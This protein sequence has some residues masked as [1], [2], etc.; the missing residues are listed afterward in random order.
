M[1]WF[2]VIGGKALEFCSGIR[3]LN[4]YAACL[5]QPSGLKIRS[6]EAGYFTNFSA[7]RRGRAT[8]S[9][10]QLGHRPSSTP[11]AH[12]RQNVHSN[13]QIRAS[14]DSGGRSTLQHSQLGRS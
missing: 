3:I 2:G 13:E 14:D 8:S 7:G 10:P 6:V 5:P 11:Y 4:D 12:E 1:E 9:P